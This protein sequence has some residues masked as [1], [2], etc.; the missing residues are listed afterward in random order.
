MGAP[1]ST[2]EFV[3][4]RIEGKCLKRALESLESDR[5]GEVGKAEKAGERWEWVGARLTAT[6]G[7]PGNG[8]FTLEIILQKVCI[9]P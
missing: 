1:Q 4:N 6:L 8:C 9:F 5:G 7:W 2:P 3:G